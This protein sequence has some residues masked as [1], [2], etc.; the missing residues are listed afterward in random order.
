MFNGSWIEQLRER[1]REPR[2]RFPLLARAFIPL[3]HGAADCRADILHE[4]IPALHWSTIKPGYCSAYIER[5]GERVYKHAQTA[6][7]IVEWWFG[8]WP[9]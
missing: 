9:K 1:S 3:E 7:E 4:M 5:N 2:Q 8:Q 6:W